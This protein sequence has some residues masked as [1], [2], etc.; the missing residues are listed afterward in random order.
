MSAEQPAE[1]KH[2][3]R[4]LV[5]MIAVPAVL[6]LLALAGA[7]WRVFHLAY[8]KRLM[9][10]DDP[11]ERARGLEMVLEHHIEKGITVEEVRR[12]IAPLKMKLTARSYRGSA[13]FGKKV[14][15]GQ[16][17]ASTAN[18]KQR[19]RWDCYNVEVP[20]SRGA[21]HVTSLYFIGREGQSSSGTF[22]S[23]QSFGLQDEFFLPGENGGAKK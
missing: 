4:M 23:H 17:A 6:L 1:T 8:C 2:S 15:F 3:R 14:L 22:T 9:R 11:R 10:S 7:N 5:W 21:S 13:F 18:L 16:G 20:L 12:R 19:D